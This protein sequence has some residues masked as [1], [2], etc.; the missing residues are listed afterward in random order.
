MKRIKFK[1]LQAGFSIHIPIHSDVFHKFNQEKDETP[2]W[3]FDNRKRYLIS[4][5]FSPANE[6]FVKSFINKL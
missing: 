5:R 4:V 2:Q 6:M 1:Y 3:F